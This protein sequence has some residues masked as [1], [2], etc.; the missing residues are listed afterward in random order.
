MF[1]SVTVAA[2]FEHRVTQFPGG[3]DLKRGFG[4]AA[5]ANVHVEAAVHLNHRYRYDF[6]AQQDR[7]LR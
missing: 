4:E 6:L 7:P 3:A 2:A 1:T 5:R